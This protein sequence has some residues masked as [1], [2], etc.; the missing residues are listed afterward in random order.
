MYC[1]YYHVRVN[2]PKIWFIVGCFRDADYVAFERALEG[3]PDILEFFVPHAHEAE[4]L[5]FIGYLV[6]HGYVLSF[7][8]MHNRFAQ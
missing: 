5:H 8:S 7:M 2:R 6:K 1:L 3:Y 4:F